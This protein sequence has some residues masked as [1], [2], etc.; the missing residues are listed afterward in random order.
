LIFFFFLLKKIF[1]FHFSFIKERAAGRSIFKCVHAH[2][3]AMMMIASWFIFHDCLKSFR[4][5]KKKKKK[6]RKEK[7]HEISQKLIQN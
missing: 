4:W 6:K 2:P 7:N 3:M 1:F 5:T